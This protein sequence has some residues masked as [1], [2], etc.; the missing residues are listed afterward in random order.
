MDNK[1]MENAHIDTVMLLGEAFRIGDEAY[2]FGSQDLTQRIQRLVPV[3]VQERLCPPPEEVYSLHRKLS[4]M[5]L[6]CSR[7]K[8][9]VKC[10][11]IFDRV[12]EDFERK[13]KEKLP[14]Q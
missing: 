1:L 12:W 6:L 10:K 7:L 2:D 3:M 8:G 11:P 5:F 9:R 13:Q 14:Q 4:G